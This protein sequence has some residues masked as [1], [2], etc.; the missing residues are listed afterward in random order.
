[1]LGSCYDLPYALILL[2]YF[3]SQPWTQ[4]GE[5][6]MLL[7]IYGND[8][9]TH[10]LHSF[11]FIASNQCN[12]FFNTVLSCGWERSLPLCPTIS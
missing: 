8:H 9:P 12:L 3:S 1:M 7:T 11:T 4:N 2:F 10:K 6:T 5:P